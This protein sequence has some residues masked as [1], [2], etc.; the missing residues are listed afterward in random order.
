[1]FY[2]GRG[3]NE[4][5]FCSDQSHLMVLGPPRS[6]KTTS[7]VIPNLLSHQGP[8]LVTSTKTDILDVT[9]SRL[10]S[11]GDVWLFDPSGTLEV[12]PGV[13]QLR[14]SPVDET[15]SL[16][17]AVVVADTL[18]DASLG[19]IRG[20][21]AHWS[22]RAKAMLAPMLLAANIAGL[23]ASD[24]V[25]WIDRR[26]MIEPV[27]ILQAGD[28]YRAAEI[29]SGLAQAEQ[30]ELSGIFSSASGALSCY[31]FE[32]AL[33][34]GTDSNFSTKQFISSSDTVF[35]ISPTSVQK[36]VAPVVVSLIDQIRAH[37][38]SAG[39]EVTNKRVM[40]LLD[41]MANIAPLPSLPSILSE[42]ASQGVSIMGCLQD[43]SQA[44]RRWPGMSKGFLTLFGTAIVLSGIADYTTL[45]N[46]SELSGRHYVP[47][48]QLQI[49]QRSRFTSSVSRSLRLNEKPLF[50]A[51]DIQ[52]MGD[53]R[54]V[55]FD[56]RREPGF[57]E[58]TPYF[59]LIK[60]ERDLRSIAQRDIAS[61]N[62]WQR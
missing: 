49:S 55:V 16:D 36:A 9:Q 42:G 29:L 23:E 59:T 51:S 34:A 7:L 57:V 58:L 40:M 4:S 43:L 25:S 56:F 45:R 52:R 12:P 17:R 33:K 26:D 50:S 60:G 13:R 21:G 39:G 14:W 53:S 1:M 6:G 54:A 31:R 46:F 32:S 24:L 11:K 47:E 22:E 8:T 28:Q 37:R 35:V 48:T 15:N 19:E 10:R 5:Q 62:V 18:V 27:A 44:E 20:E 41:E 61:D 30:R 38:Y 3:T 2:L